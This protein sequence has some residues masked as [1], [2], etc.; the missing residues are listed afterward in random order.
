MFPLSLGQLKSNI[1]IVYTGAKV[2]LFWSFDWLFSISIL[3]ILAYGLIVV[4]GSIND[5]LV[6]EIHLGIINSPF[7]EFTTS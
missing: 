5:L 2:S 7:Q 3:H 6:F 4:S 1:N